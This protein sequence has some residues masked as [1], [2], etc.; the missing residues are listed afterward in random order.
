MRRLSSA[1]RRI[2][3]EQETLGVDK[4]KPTIKPTIKPTP[5]P[6][7]AG[8]E[9]ATLELP[10]LTEPPAD[11]PEIGDVELL[12]KCREYLE[13]SISNLNKIG[14]ILGARLKDFST[15]ESLL[16]VNSQLDKVI[17]AV[18]ERILRQ[19]SKDG[20]DVSAMLPGEQK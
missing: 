12:Q 7:P 11:Q 6:E 19:A 13:E 20:Y 1:Q 10:E 18:N 4:L 17:D 5:K 3:S 9:L 14:I 15:R 8:D 16:A 2:I